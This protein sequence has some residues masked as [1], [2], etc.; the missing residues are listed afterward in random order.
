MKRLDQFL[1]NLKYG[2]RKETEEM[3]KQ[4]L[5]KIDGLIAHSGK[6]KIDPL[7]NEIKVNQEVVFYKEPCDLMIYKP[8][9]YLSSNIDEKYPSVMNLIKPPYDRFDFKIAGRLDYD[10]EGLLILTTDG[11]LVHQITHPTKEISKIYEVTLDK[12]FHAKD[13][14]TLLNGV[15][16]KDGKNETYTAKALEISEVL[17]KVHIKI[18]EGKFHQVKRM[19]ESVGYEVLNLKRIQIGHLKLINLSQGEYQEIDRNDIF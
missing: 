18:S 6:Q 5:V 15:T 10:S 12:P 2:S 11:K 13:G 7:K 9:G 1:S 14:K 4:G 16:I 17:E 3:I 19:F 8:K